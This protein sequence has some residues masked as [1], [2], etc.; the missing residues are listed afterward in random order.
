MS[1]IEQKWTRIVSY[2]R[3]AQNIPNTF[4]ADAEKSG[5][6]SQLLFM[7]N[8]EDWR[9]ILFT[10]QNLQTIQANYSNIQVDVSY[11]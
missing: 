11:A 2:P 4:Y 6:P 10:L 9:I 5:P 7:N 8:V 3:V 1:T